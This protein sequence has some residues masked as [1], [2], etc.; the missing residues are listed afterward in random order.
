MVRKLHFLAVDRLDFSKGIED[1]N[2]CAQALHE[3]TSVMIFPEGT[4]G[5]AVG[6]R[7]FKLG[8]FK[9]A[10][11]AGVPVCP[12]SMKGTRLIL[13]DD[14]RLLSWGRITVTICEPVMPDGDDWKSVTK[15]REQVRKQIALYCG[16]P[17]LD[18][19][20]AQAIAPHFNRD[21]Q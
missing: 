7:P 12:I 9:M 18:L 17:T 3:G 19:I 11:E 5:Y 6:L 1:T 10:A 21:Y 16:E 13:R 4:F 20:I 15:L 2:R 8:A 14:S